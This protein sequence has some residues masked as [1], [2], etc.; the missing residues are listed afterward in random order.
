MAD[1]YTIA[2]Y[3][4]RTDNSGWNEIQGTHIGTLEANPY[5]YNISSPIQL[6]FNFRFMDQQLTTSNVFYVNGSGSVIFDP[7]WCGYFDFD[8]YSIYFPGSSYFPYDLWGSEYSSGGACY[9]PGYKLM[10]LEALSYNNFATGCEYTW[11]VVGSAPNRQLVVQTKTRTGYVGGIVGSWQAIV[12]ENGISKFEF[13]YGPITGNVG[14][15]YFGLDQGSNRYGAISG[16]KGGPGY[17]FLTIGHNG[18]GSPS[19]LYNNPNYQDNG[20]GTSWP[21]VNYTISIAYPSDMTALNI[22]APLDQSIQTIGSLQTPVVTVMNSG[23]T[24]PTSAQVLLQ[25][26][27]A[28]TGVV[29]NRSVT[30]TGA[31]VPLPFTSTAV[32][33]P[34]FAVP[35]FGIYYDTAIVYNLLPTA[36]QNPVDNSITNTW[37]CSPPNNIKAIGV[38][39]PAPGTRSPIAVPTPITIRFKNIGTINQV[40]VPLT[41]VVKDPNGMVVLR[42]TVI[43]PYMPSPNTSVQYSSLDTTFDGWVP[44]VNGTYTVCGIAIMP[45]D[46]LRADDTVCAPIIIRYEADVA[47]NSVV[48]PQPDEEKPYTLSWQP[49]ALFQSIGVA[50]LFEVPARLQIRRCT[51]GQLMFQ[52]DSI[53]PELNVDQNQVRFLFPSKQGP[54]DIAKLPPGCY[55]ICAIAKYPTDGDR[56]S[57]TACSTFSIIDRLKGNIFVGVGQRFQSVHAAVDS[58]LFRG[59]GGNLNLI[60]TDPTYTENGN[61]RISS[62]WG[63]LD[64]SHVRGLSDTSWVTWMPKPGVTPTITFT[65]NKPYCFYFGDQFGGHVK[66]EG[67][68]PLGVPIPDKAVAEPNKRGM[69]IIDNASVAGGVFGV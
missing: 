10:P 48:N 42:D 67:Y 35:A 29:Y 6:P 65:G 17:S 1:G 55:N 66:F 58:M 19:V 39:S 49:A 37:T 44:A 53:I 45:S 57:D 31:Q 28:G 12:F 51:D 40:N 63:A 26:T 36:D 59:I 69:T 61:T 3:Q 8:G 15:N 21:T 64:F 9:D 20:Y 62:P 18:A 24:R 41:C 68:S 32:A 13:S 4:V 60:L 54:Y 27:Q 43:A 34:S 2:D 52:A 7:S 56:T 11:A 25:I 33:F 16:V 22:T 38:L 46:Q 47:A 30:L 14:G 50:D 23:S 5:Y